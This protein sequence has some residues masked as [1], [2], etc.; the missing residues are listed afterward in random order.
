[1]TSL[2]VTLGTRTVYDDVNML[3][4]GR[5][6][7]AWTEAKRITRRH[8]CNNTTTVVNG[9]LRVGAMVFVGWSVAA[10]SSAYLLKAY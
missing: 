8:K 4:T 5:G 2:G 1:M 6:V 9:V 10:I 3:L 7:R